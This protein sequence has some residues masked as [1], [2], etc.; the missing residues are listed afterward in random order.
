MDSGNVGST[1]VLKTTGNDSLE[2]VSGLSG[3]LVGDGNSSVKLTVLGVSV[4]NSLENV[5][6]LPEVSDD[7]VEETSLERLDE[8]SL[9]NV[10]DVSGV[11]VEGK[12]S[13]KLVGPSGVFVGEGKSS[14]KLDELAGPLGVSVGKGNSSV[15]LNVLN[16]SDR[17]SLVGKE[18]VSG[19]PEISETGNKEKDAVDTKLSDLVDDAKIQMEVGKVGDESDNVSTDVSV[20]DGKDEKSKGDDDSISEAGVAPPVL[21]VFV[22]VKVCAVVVESVNVVNPVVSTG[23]DE[24]EGMTGDTSVL[25]GMTGETSVLLVSS[26]PVGMTGDTSVLLVGTEFD[27]GLGSTRLTLENPIEGGAEPTAEPGEDRDE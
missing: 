10:M 8:S 21:K 1:S 13:E 12:S 15:K 18:R 4:K 11:V 19:L 20:E 7:N 16:V 2:D 23:N 5:I 22:T 3:V 24:L 9:E 26:M 14:V 27:K 25:L 6:G 17:D